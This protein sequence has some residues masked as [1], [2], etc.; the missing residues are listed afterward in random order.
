MK[1]SKKFFVLQVTFLHYINSLV[2]LLNIAKIEQLQIKI[3]E[4]PD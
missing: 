4:T 3:N 2:P 1:P